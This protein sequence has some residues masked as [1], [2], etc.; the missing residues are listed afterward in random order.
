VARSRPCKR[1]ELDLEQQQLNHGQLGTCMYRYYPF[2]SKLHFFRNNF[3]DITHFHSLI[4]LKTVPVIRYPKGHVPGPSDTPAVITCLKFDDSHS[5]LW[6]GDSMGYLAS[7]NG[8]KLQLYTSA[9]AHNGPIL[10]ILNHKKGILS[11]SFDSVRLGTEEGATL[12][13]IRSDELKG[14]NSMSFTSNTQTELLVG[15]DRDATGSRIFRI[16]TVHHRISGTINYPHT[17]VFMDTNLKYIIIGRSDGKVDVFDPRTNRILETFKAHLSG[18]SHMAVKDNSFYTTGFSV[19]KDQF[20]PDLFVNSFDL[21]TL[22]PLAPIPFPGGASKV[23]TH[24]T[25]PNVIL[26]CSSFGH[27]NFLDVKSPTNLKIYQAELNSYITSFD[28]AASASFLAFTDCAGNLQ[29]W[30]RTA[31]NAASDFAPYIAPLAYPS[32]TTEVIPFKNHLVSPE[33]PFNL[34]KLPPFHKPLLSAWPG[35][36]VF[37]VGKIPEHIDPEILRS[38]EVINGFVIARY[39]KEKFGPRNVAKPYYDITVPTIDGVSVPRFISERNVD[40]EEDYADDAE[41]NES[42]DFSATTSTTK[43]SSKRSL[44]SNE[45]KEVAALQSHIFDLRS[46]NGDV[47]NAYKQLSIMYSKFGVDD[48]DFDF[49]NKTRYS[50]LEINS[51]NSFLNP[52][53]QLYRHVAPIFNYSLK[54][55]AEDVTLKPSVLME[56]GYLYDMM[57]KS[58][59]RHCAPSNFQILLSQIQEIQALGLAN[60]KNVSRDDIKQRRLIQTF[61]R[62]LLERL[63]Q[64]ERDLYHRDN[65]PALDEITGVVTET[66]IYSNFCSLTHKRVAMYHSIDINCLPSPPLTPTSVTIL[67]YMEASMNKRLQQNIVCENCRFQHP[68]NASLEINNLPPVVILNLDLNNQQMNEIR[69]LNGWLVPEF[70]FAQSPLRT[71][72]L[73]TNVIGGVASNLKKYELVGCTVQI[74]NRQNE[75]HLVTYSKI[76]DAEGNGKWYLFNDFLVTEVTQEEALD[77]SHWWKKPVVMVYK[78]VGVDDTFRPKIY[79]DKLDTSI[80][81]KDRFADNGTR[82]GKTIEYNLLEEGEVIKPGTLVALDAEFIELSPAEYEFNGNGTKTLVSPPKSLLARISVIRGEEPKEGECFI[83]DYIATSENIHDY[84]TAYSG[85]V[86]GDLTVEK[87]SKSLVTLQVAYRRIWLLLNLGCVFIG[88]WLTGD[89]RMI[90]IYIPPAQVRDTGLC[91]YLKKEKRI[92]GLKFLAHYVLDKEAQAGNHDSIEDSTNALLLYKEYLKLKGAGALE[93]MLYKL[94][95]EGQMTGFRVPTEVTLRKE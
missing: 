51:G 7:Y 11:L 32:P 8:L 54:S 66:S 10:K 75:N 60:E 47:P 53:I 67:N 85:I 5:L 89:F 49:Y 28:L 63:S 69:Y 81:Y 70:Y 1:V 9:K 31:I 68:V 4:Q 57:W 71:P 83:D 61:N 37:K 59:G 21:K 34:I 45:S 38:S 46:I 26:I 17:V 84:K 29:L 13:N 79:M 25:I 19:K 56:L 44:T 41:A 55:L 74:T 94:Y 39:N 16:D 92:L 20:T 77:I 86:E 73:R 52:I 87:S 35:D 88:H 48:F 65:S 18:L 2:T 50:G 30:N 22:S 23:F 12:F 42:A 36:L 80:L 40:D 27:M 82:D 15:G 6:V 76:K 72:V 33:S 93:R 62:F 58:E 91:F 95:L 14:L 43:S 90:N 78:Q 24:P 3:T 64:D